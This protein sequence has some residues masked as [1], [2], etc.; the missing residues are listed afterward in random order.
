[1]EIIITQ[2]KKLHQVLVPTTTPL[3]TLTTKPQSYINT[4]SRYT[5]HETQMKIKSRQHTTTTWHV[6]LNQKKSKP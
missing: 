2:T 3:Q 1:M 4:D 6:G 5:K